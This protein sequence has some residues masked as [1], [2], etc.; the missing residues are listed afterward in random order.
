MFSKKGP[1]SP[2]WAAQQSQ[3]GLSDPGSLSPSLP[4]SLPSAHHPWT[5]INRPWGP[6]E[7][8]PAGRGSLSVLCT[9]SPSTFLDAFPGELCTG[10]CGMRRHCFLSGSRCDSE[11]EWCC[12]G[13]YS[14]KKHLP[15]LLLAHGAQVN[16][17]RMTKAVT[18][19]QASA[20]SDKRN[21]QQQ[22]GDRRINCRD[23][24]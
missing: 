16:P 19:K 20:I 11:A 9:T 14:L 17:Q 6:A 5:W 18:K 13:I 4:L 3:Q 23:V 1:L 10:Q 21:R 24:S 7:S 2:A 22:E 15:L 12:W 8:L